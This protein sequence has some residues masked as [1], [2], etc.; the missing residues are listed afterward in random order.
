M[1]PSEKKNGKWHAMGVSYFLTKETGK[2]LHTE[3][4]GGNRNEKP[5][6]PSENGTKFSEIC[7]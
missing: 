2:I 7:L 5:Q 4:G 6:G 1:R 3:R